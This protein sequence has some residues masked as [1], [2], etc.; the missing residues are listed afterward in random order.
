MKKIKHLLLFLIAIWM[1]QL[2]ANSA[3]TG[4]IETG[5]LG[6]GMFNQLQ[7]DG[8]GVY[9]TMQKDQIKR[10]NV[11]KNLISP[12]E[13][14][15]TTEDEDK[16][17]VDIQRDLEKDGVVYNPQFL[18]R[19]VK[20]EGNT[21]IKSKVL[22]SIGSDVIDHEI[23]FEDL[24]TYALRISRYYQSKGYLTSYAYVPAQQIKDGVVTICIV[25]STVGDVEVTGNKWA[26]T[27]YLKN[28]MM[29]R[30]GL[31][32]GTVFNARA[33]QGAL[34]EMNEETYMQAQSTIS[35]NGDDT[36]IDLEVRDKFPL[37]FNFS[38]DDYGRTY[39]G[40]Q[41]ASFL[42]GLD[43]LSGFGD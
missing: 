40:V 7:R 32:E 29:G 18:V 1:W 26:R 16:F 12:V 27:W 33:L 5:G 17:E 39:T 6:A 9:D 35:K 34:R 41:R 36:K 28:V 21:K 10:Y 2:P 38:W 37:R 11:E 25:E 4:V 31:R 3:P 20:F 13:K 23:Y 42:L 22:E 14:I 15:Q 24:L 8:S 30:D 19:K 43:N